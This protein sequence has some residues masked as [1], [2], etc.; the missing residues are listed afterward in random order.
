MLDLYGSSLDV[1]AATTVLS[2]MAIIGVAFLAS[3]VKSK[4]WSSLHRLLRRRDPQPSTLFLRGLVSGPS[5][6]ALDGLQAFASIA[7]ATHRAV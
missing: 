7:D 6:E 2:W 4:P 3:F 5:A 1:I